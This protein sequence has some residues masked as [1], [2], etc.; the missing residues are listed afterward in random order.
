MG[1]LRGI[2]WPPRIEPESGRS[3]EGDP[4]QG[5]GGETRKPYREHQPRRDEPQPLWQVGALAQAGRLATV[6]GWPLHLL[7][8]LG[9]SYENPNCQVIQYNLLRC[10]PIRVG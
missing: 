1:W 4:R 2:R 10:A 7:P 3:V 6:P 5:I 8:T 9:E